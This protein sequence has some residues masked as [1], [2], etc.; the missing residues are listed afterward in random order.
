M[1]RYRDGLAIPDCVFE[2]AAWKYQVEITCSCGHLA[3]HDPHGLWHFCEKK[4]WSDNF[5]DLYLR[6]YCLRCMVSRKQKVRPRKIDGT[7]EPATIRLPWPSELEWKRAI[8]R[9]R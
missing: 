5:Q 1:T 7:K 6:F 9:F 3:R 8:S 4:R 2:A